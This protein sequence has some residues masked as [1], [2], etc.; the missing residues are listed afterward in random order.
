MRKISSIT[1]FYTSKEVE[2][3]FHFGLHL[4]RTSNS[5]SNVYDGEL[6]SISDVEYFCGQPITSL[7]GLVRVDGSTVSQEGGKKI[8]RLAAPLREPPLA[9][10][11]SRS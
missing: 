11:Y 6:Y 3:R 5:G 1:S 10:T 7:D 2:N 8:F 9:L 4:T